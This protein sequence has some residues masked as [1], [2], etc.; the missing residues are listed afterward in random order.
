MILVVSHADDVHAAAVLAALRRR[1]APARLLDVSRFP[2]RLR[3]TLTRGEGA[4]GDVLVPARDAPLRLDALTAVWWRRP[5]PFVLHDELDGEERRIFAWR[6]GREAMSG[7][8]QSLDV[9]W[10]NHPVRDDAAARKPWQLAVATR[11]G[12]RVPRTCITT[13]P[14]RARA[15]LASLGPRRAVVKALQAT[16][17]DWRP[18]RLL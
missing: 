1:G 11:V 15:F 12:L 7:M 9:R 13:D 14:R 2:R 18:T 8:W 6:E 4:D 17:A 16:R 5:L 10:V 3:L